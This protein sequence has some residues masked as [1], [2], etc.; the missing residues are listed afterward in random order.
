MRVS[1]VSLLHYSA[2]LLV[3]AKQSV[4]NGKLYKFEVTGMVNAA[5]AVQH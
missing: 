1:S 3:L 4:V 5:H 2:L